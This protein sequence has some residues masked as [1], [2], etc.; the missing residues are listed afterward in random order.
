MSYIIP[1]GNESFMSAKMGGSVWVL[2]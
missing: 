1:I 2:W